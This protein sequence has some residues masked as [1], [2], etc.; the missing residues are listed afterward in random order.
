[1]PQSS[2]TKICLKI[3]CLKFH[4]NFPGA[5]ELPHRRRVVHIYISKLGHLWFGTGLSPIRY[6]VIFL[7]QCWLIFKSVKFESKCKN[8]YTRKLNQT[9]RLHK[10]TFCT[11][12]LTQMCIHK[13]QCT[14]SIRICVHWTQSKTKQ[15]HPVE[16][17]FKIY[18]PLY[19]SRF[20]KK[21][22]SS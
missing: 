20:L 10:G 13:T 12:Y 4:S 2:I 21:N 9:C 22:R 11:F 18:V 8:S 17:W 5:N 15:S 7:N 6:Q 16:M 14:I 19:L 3:T 1:M